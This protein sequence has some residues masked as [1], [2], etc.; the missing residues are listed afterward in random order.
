MNFRVGIRLAP[1][2]SCQI[3][4]FIQRING[5]NTIECCY[6]QRFL[7]ITSKSCSFHHAIFYKYLMLD[8]NVQGMFEPLL[9]II[10]SF[11]SHFNC[12]NS[13]KKYT[14]SCNS[15]LVQNFVEFDIKK[16]ATHLVGEF[17]LVS[18]E[19]SLI[20]QA[21]DTLLNSN[22]LTTI[23]IFVFI[24]VVHVCLC[25]TSRT[26][27]CVCVFFSQLFTQNFLLRFRLRPH[28]AQLSR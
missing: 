25:F 4:A 5:I 10:S 6:F 14:I 13:R 26:K 11:S 15:D 8:S 17:V 19:N 27:M 23:A 16:T 22:T 1:S 3:I 18:V 21:K 7:S 20:L 28:R 9:T 12:T 2:H 24:L